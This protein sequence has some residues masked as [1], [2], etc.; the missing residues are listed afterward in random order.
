MFDVTEY[1]LQIALDH[2]SKLIHIN[3]NFKRQDRINR[4]MLG[5]LITFGMYIIVREKERREMKYKVD[6]ISKELEGET[7]C[8][9]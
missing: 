3:R 8:N 4:K 1:L 6:R 9:D 5:L 2:G 7:K